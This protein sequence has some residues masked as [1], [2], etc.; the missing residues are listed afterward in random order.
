MG[1]SQY[2]ATVSG[3]NRFHIRFKVSM[4][5]MVIA[6]PIEVTS[7]SAVPFVAVGAVCDTKAENC[8][9]SAITKQPHII[10]L[11]RKING[12]AK[13]KRGDS[14]QQIPDIIKD[15]HATLALPI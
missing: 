6:K 4:L 3:M 8:G 5:T 12:D 7:V 2:L 13:K 15:I 1:K 10:K 9:E 11:I 14:K